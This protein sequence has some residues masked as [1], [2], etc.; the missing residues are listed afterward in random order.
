MFLPA[1]KKSIYVC[2]H[3]GER[4]WKCA[5]STRKSISIKVVAVA[6]VKIATAPTIPSIWL[7][8]THTCNAWW[9]GCSV[10]YDKMR[11][12][13][14]TTEQSMLK[15]FREH[16]DDVLQRA[17]K[18]FLCFYFVHHPPALFHFAEIYEQFNFRNLSKVHTYSHP[19]QQSLNYDG[20]VCVHVHWTKMSSQNDDGGCGRGGRGFGSRNTKES[21]FE[22]RKAKDFLNKCSKWW[23]KPSS[24]VKNYFWLI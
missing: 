6:V 8:R 17:R 14:W 18:P 22:R 1:A 21:D 11:A 3:G 23:N 19:A 4:K 24:I 20:G 12:T 13:A 10:M 9:M 15:Y 7:S 5:I 2:V 16:F